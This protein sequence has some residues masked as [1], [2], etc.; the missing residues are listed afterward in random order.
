MAQDVANALDQLGKPT[1][2]P[3]APEAATLETVLNPHPE[4]RYVVALP[5]PSSRRCARSRAS[6][7]SRSS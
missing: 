4:R 3:A 2:V 1:R 6:P 5:A 7:I